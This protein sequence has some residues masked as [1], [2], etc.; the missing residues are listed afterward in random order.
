MSNILKTIKD[1][2]EV[3]VN[4][5]KNGDKIIE[6]LIISA[7]I[8]NETISTEALAE[9][10]R[11]RDICLSCPFN[12]IN[13]TKDGSYVTTLNFEHCVLCKCRLGKGDTEDVWGK[14]ACLDCKCGAEAFNKINPHLPPV[15]VRW[16]EF[17]GQINKEQ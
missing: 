11:R 12:S 8:K 2:T 3:V 7:K 4:G 16:T 15:E 1:Y 17:K 13:A 14:E 5:I 6:T 10:L 9:I